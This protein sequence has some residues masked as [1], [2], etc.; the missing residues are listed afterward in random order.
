VSLVG[1][2]VDAFCPRCRL[3]LA[4]VVLYEVAGTV[5][6]V[7]CRTCG[8]QHGYRGARPDRRPEIPA[9]RPQGI[10]GSVPARP[11]PVR[12]ADSRQWERRSAEAPA[13]AVAWE[14]KLTERYEKG[15]VIEHPQFGRG[16]V[17]QIPTDTS[18]EVLFR[19]GR[20]RMAM[21]RGEG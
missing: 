19:G 15:D 4:H 3:T 10:R 13:D 9:E 17:E 18:M 11:T 1:R 12:P 14:Y 5:R 16:F 6:R 21:N 20:K 7:Q 2:N 8:I